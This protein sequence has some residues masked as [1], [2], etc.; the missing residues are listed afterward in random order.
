M[1]AVTWSKFDTTAGSTA[2]TSYPGLLRVGSSG[3][4][5]RQLQQALANR[6]YSLTVDGA[7]GP[8]TKN[9]VMS[10]QRSQGIAADGIV[11]SVTWGKL[12]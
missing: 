10:F 1:G 4:G 12:F 3:T 7:F 8:M 5:V 6:G 11:G 9:A 2:G